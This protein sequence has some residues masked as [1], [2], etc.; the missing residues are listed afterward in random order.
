[1][2]KRDDKSSVKWKAY[3]NSFN[4]WIDKKRYHYIKM[5]YYKEPDNYC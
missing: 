5:S 3:D 1:M 4:S 2:Q